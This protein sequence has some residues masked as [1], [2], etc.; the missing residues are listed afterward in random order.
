MQNNPC[1][2]QYQPQKATVVNV[3]ALNSINP[4]HYNSLKLRPNGA[5]QKKLLSLLLDVTQNK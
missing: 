5:V 4:Q 2:I 1:D 3:L